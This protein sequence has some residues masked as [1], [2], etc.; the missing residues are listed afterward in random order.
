MATTT[1][2]LDVPQRLTFETAAAHAT[3]EVP[4]AEPTASDQR[5]TVPG[6]CGKIRA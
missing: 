5:D 1:L 6:G 2:S 3:K 4:I